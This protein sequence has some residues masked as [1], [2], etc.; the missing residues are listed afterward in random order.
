MSA[1]RMSPTSCDGRT[2]ALQHGMANRGVKRQCQTSL[3]MVEHLQLKVVLYWWQPQMTIIDVLLISTRIE[4]DDPK[5]T[6]DR[7]F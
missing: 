5:P 1:R 6:N 2:E 7:F 4:F 3:A